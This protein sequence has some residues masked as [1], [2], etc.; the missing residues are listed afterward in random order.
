MM[1]E[2]ESDPRHGD[3]L[4]PVRLLRP[5]R[6]IQHPLRSASHHK[7]LHS[8]L[9]FRIQP[10]GYIAPF[11]VP[12]GQKW[13][14]PSRFAIDLSNVEGVY[15]IFSPLVW[16][17]IITISVFFFW[18]TTRPVFAVM[19]LIAAVVVGVFLALYT[20]GRDYPGGKKHKQ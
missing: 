15:Y 11:D 10:K 13:N 20:V 2:V 4:R 14:P 3:R 5:K 1:N 7:P 17:H 8:D 16:I 9:K 19:I 6:H 12:L 18:L